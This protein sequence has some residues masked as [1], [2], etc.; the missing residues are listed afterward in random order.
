MVLGLKLTIS[1]LCTKM[2]SLNKTMLSPIKFS[3]LFVVGITGT[4]GQDSWSSTKV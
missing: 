3:M 2:V 1:D 4:F